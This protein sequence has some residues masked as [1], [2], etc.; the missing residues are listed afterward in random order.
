MRRVTDSSRTP[1]MLNLNRSGPADDTVRG[2]P[3]C[4]P[5]C[6]RG[7][8]EPA[9]ALPHVEH[10]TTVITDHG[11]EQHRSEHKAP[12]RRHHVAG[13]GS[14]PTI[15]HG[16]LNGGTGD[17]EQYAELAH[18]FLGPILTLQMT[19]RVRHHNRFE[20]PVA[21]AIPRTAR[22]ADPDLRI[23]PEHLG[24][25]HLPCGNVDDGIIGVHVTQATTWHRRPGH[26]S[27][28]P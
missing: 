11:S 21:L 1:R 23:A 24:F 12:T 8:P 7:D 22:L 3:R 25:D 20:Q 15:A 26:V 5:D 19:G 17:P 14:S 13:D 6:G 27:T 10:A 9:C 4:S 28:G 18:D 16:E 2:R